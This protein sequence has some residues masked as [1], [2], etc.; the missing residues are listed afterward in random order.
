MLWRSCDL[1]SRDLVLFSHNEVDV[2]DFQRMVCP[3]LYA[4][5]WLKDG[6]GV[7]LEE[8][9]LQR[10]NYFGWIM[11]YSHIG[12]C[13][14]HYSHLRKDQHFYECWR[15]QPLEQGSK[16]Q[17]CLCFCTEWEELFVWFILRFE[18]SCHQPQILVWP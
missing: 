17:R 11:G 13:S 6:I 5:I 7:S 15:W 1:P 14:S 2:I 12:D 3:T 10:E 9:L 18:M 4:M 8:P 16:G